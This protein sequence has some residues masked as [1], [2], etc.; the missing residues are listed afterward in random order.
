MTS[1]SDDTPAGAAQ[2]YPLGEA[3]RS[4]QYDSKAECLYALSPTSLYRKGRNDANFSK[5]RTIVEPDI[6][7]AVRPSCYSFSSYG[8]MVCVTLLFDQTID[9]AWIGDV[10]EPGPGRLI[11]L[12]ITSPRSEHNVCFDE[13]GTL[14]I[15]TTNSVLYSR[16][17]GRRFE[18]HKYLNE[19]LQKVATKCKF[20][21]QNINVRHPGRTTAFIGTTIGAMVLYENDDSFDTAL[22]S[23]ANVRSTVNYGYDPYWDMLVSWIYLVDSGNAVRT[24]NM[25]MFVGQRDDPQFLLG[26]ASPGVP[27]YTMD[28]DITA[29]AVSSTTSVSTGTNFYLAAPAPQGSSPAGTKQVLWFAGPNTL[30]DVNDTGFALPTKI[31]PLALNCMYQYAGQLYIGTDNG[32]VEYRESDIIPDRSPGMLR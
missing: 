28:P 3:I 19:E 10:G 8:D 29:I 16:D 22:F 14:Y 30:E 20:E 9:T 31:A 12:R 2:S 23:D 32:I 21:V 18:P 15:A 25:K 27:S 17:Q 7:N 11:R 1:H 4:I 13:H 24:V 6:S 26:T 5:V